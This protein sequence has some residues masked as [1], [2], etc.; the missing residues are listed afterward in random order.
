MHIYLRSTSR[1]L[2]RSWALERGFFDEIICTFYA[3]DDTGEAS[4]NICS[5]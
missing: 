4:V 3:F 1:F 5:F 2:G